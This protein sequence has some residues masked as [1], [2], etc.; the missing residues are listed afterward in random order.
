MSTSLRTACGQPVDRSG[1]P[2]VP[3]LAGYPYTDVATPDLAYQDTRR[4]GGRSSG[5][6]CGVPTRAR[7]VLVGATARPRQAAV[8]RCRLTRP[9]AL[10]RWPRIAWCRLCGRVRASGRTPARRRAVGNATPSGPGSPAARK[11][12]RNRMA[13][14]GHERGAR[15]MFSHAGPRPGC[16]VP[17]L[18]RLWLPRPVRPGRVCSAAFYASSRCRRT[19]TTQRRRWTVITTGNASE[20]G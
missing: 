20:P 14:R 17:H 18:N 12:A 1:A 7:P 3:S 5:L 11:R 16:W 10:P 13:R 19:P 2:S 15:L 8:T 4:R 9:S 6:W